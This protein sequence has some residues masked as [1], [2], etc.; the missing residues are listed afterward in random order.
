MTAI[1]TV[2][3]I[4]IAA[5]YLIGAVFNSVW[6]MGHTVEFYGGFA[7]GAWLRPARSAVREL[8][9]PNARL[10]TVLLV[11]FQVTVAVLILIRG[12]LVKAALIAGGVFALVAGLASSPG[13]T[14]GNTVLAGIQFTLAWA[15]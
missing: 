2:G 14:A 10:F 11:L 8:I 3:E 9:L 13:G 15:R 12:D 5:I 1:R 4:G 6:T 7:D